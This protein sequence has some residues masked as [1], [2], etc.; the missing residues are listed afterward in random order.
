MND[1][2]YT[3]LFEKIVFT[4]HARTRM[5]ER[6]IN[7]EQVLEALENPVQ[8]VYDKWNDVYIAVDQRG[9]AIVYAYRG[10]YIEILTVLGK[11]EYEALVSKYGYS[12]YRVI[13]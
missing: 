3:V 7:E 12:R 11:R 5:R 8:H 2:G 4:K 1:Q 6:D 9:F 13:Q 10:S